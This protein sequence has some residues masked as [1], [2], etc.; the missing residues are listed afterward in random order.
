M[1]RVLV[2][3]FLALSLGATLLSAEA[4]RVKREEFETTIQEL[5][6]ADV[7]GRAATA[8]VGSQ[9]TDLKADNAALNGK[10]ETLEFLLSQS[11]EQVNQMQADD[12]EL[13]QL[14][15]RLEKRL[16]SQDAKIRSLE[17]Q[18]RQ[19]ATVAQPFAATGAGETQNSAPTTETTGNRPQ[20]LTPQAA[21]ETT[22]APAQV[23]GQPTRIVRTTTTTRDQ[24]AGENALPQGTLGTVSA[25]SLPG[26]AGPLFAEAKN[27]LL[28]FDYTGAELAFRAFLEDFG[29]D[30]QAGEAQYWL[31]EALYQKE[32]YAES[33]QAYTDMI[34]AYP[35][36]PRAPEALAKLA[37]AM[38]LVGDTDRA[39]NALDLLPQRYP[40]AS[41]LTKNL[42]AGERVRSGCDS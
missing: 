14:I 23:T 34:R 30:P 35:D 40:N 32:A 24:L 8:N 7:D 29:D 17:A 33:G 5:R 9:I 13:A 18:M 22:T 6:N 37:R 36:D 41:G 39:C 4:Q 3:S 25:S 11:R 26:E 28:R 16:S 38:R 19:A 1:F 12:A 31:A 21:S 20:S 42:A 15:D 10:V 27:R 2:L